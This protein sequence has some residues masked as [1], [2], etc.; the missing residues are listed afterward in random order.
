MKPMIPLAALLVAG[1]QTYVPIETERAPVPAECKMKPFSDLPAV[2]ELAGEKATPD[3]LNKHWAR[4][5][6]LKARPRYWM[7]R[8]AYKVCATYAAKK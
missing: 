2:P 3:Q 1:C 6:R 4:H 7:L 5:Y 8:D